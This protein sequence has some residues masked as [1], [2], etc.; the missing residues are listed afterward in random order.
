[1]KKCIHLIF[2]I[3]YLLLGPAFFNQGI[4]LFAEEDFII[5]SINIPDELKDIELSEHLLIEDIN[6]DMFLDLIFIVKN[7]IYIL[8]QINN[9]GFSEFYNF[10]VNIS[11]AID[12]GDVVPGGEKEILIMHQNGISYFERKFEKWISSPISLIEE[13]TVYDKHNTRYLK[14]EHLAVDLDGDDILELILWG[15]KAINIYSKINNYKYKLLKSIRYESKEHLVYPG[16]VIADS[17][18][19]WMNRESSKNL[20]K[21]R[22]PDNIKYLYFTTTQISNIYLIRD[23]NSDL[24]K[25]LIEIKHVEI[26]DS[27]KG[28]YTIYEYRV[29]FFN[30]NKKITEIPDAVISDPYGAWLSPNCVDINNDGTLDLLRVEMKTTGDSLRRNKC[31][32]MLFLSNRNGNYPSE[33]TQIIETSGYPF[34]REVLID[35]DG[36]KK[37]DLILIH[38]ITQGFSLGSIVNKFL[39]KGIN[40]EIQ[41]LPFRD[42]SGF[43]KDDIIRKKIKIKFIAGIPISLSGDFNGDGMR[44]LLIVDKERIKIYPLLTHKKEFSRYPK[45]KFAIEDLDSYI[46]KDFNNDGKS[47]LVIF[48]KDNNCLKIINFGSSPN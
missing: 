14:R 29:Y 22:W 18:L 9:L 5:N 41:I 16:L 24:K 37:K 26:Q 39:E 21:N 32:I 30:K 46:V 33:P 13:K 15:N 6:Q 25:D 40:A 34:G 8:Y 48:T 44:D 20:F 43:S 38:P 42:G 1:M 11:G 28:N 17:P 3:G 10:L 31:K 19:V 27:K 35:V 4:S 47:D 2:F 12:F 36:D 23:F 45:I 7:K